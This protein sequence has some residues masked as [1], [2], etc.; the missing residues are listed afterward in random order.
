MY[1]NK[2]AIAFLVRSVA[3]GVYSLVLQAIEE[4]LRRDVVLTISFA[5]HRAAHA[6]RQ[7][8]TQRQQR[9]VSAFQRLRIAVGLAQLEIGQI[10]PDQ[11]V[12]AIRSHVSAKWVDPPATRKADALHCDEVMHILGHRQATSHF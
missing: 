10:N 12:T 1:S 5:A 11:G 2:S 4:A 3:R 7:D 8:L 9:I 6:I